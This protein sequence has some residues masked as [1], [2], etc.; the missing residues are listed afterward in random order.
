ALG[1]FGG[2]LGGHFSNR[3]PASV[4]H[5]ASWLLRAIGLAAALCAYILLTS[6]I[7][8][9]IAEPVQFVLA[10]I[11][12]TSVLIFFWRSFRSAKPHS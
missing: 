2:I 10:F 7:D 11:A 3:L 5:D 4:L 9:S 8:F 12:L 1:M 6:K